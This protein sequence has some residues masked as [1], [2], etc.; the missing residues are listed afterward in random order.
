MDIIEALNPAA[1]TEYLKKF[2]NTICG[3]HPIGVLLQVKEYKHIFIEGYISHDCKLT[4][5]SLQIIF[6][7]PPMY[8]IVNKLVHE[9]YC[10]KSNATA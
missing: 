8:I 6:I 4:L 9:V 2:G 5:S 3:R 10:D 1:F 7:F